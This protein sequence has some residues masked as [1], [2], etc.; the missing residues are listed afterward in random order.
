AG[1]YSSWPRWDGP[2]A[3]PNSSGSKANL[4]PTWD[5]QTRSGRVED[6]S[7]DSVPVRGAPID[8]PRP[9]LGSPWPGACNL[10]RLAGRCY[11]LPLGR[12]TRHH[13]AACS[14]VQGS[15]SL[16]LARACSRVLASRN[17]SFGS[18]FRHRITTSSRSLG[19]SGRHRDGGSANSW[20]WAARVRMALSR[21]NGGLPVKR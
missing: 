18:F 10:T 13:S 8:R 15:A 6:G 16:H 19:M 14:S 4:V 9:Y 7:A 5:F 21:T 1:G 17:R 20:I 12:W 2:V 11:W 3:R